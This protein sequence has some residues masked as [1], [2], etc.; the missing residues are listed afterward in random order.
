MRCVFQ[1]LFALLIGS[2]IAAQTPGV[3]QWR[4]HL[5]YS[6]IIAV[7]ES[8]DRVYA[9]ASG[10]VFALVKADN[11]LERLSK[12]N[13]LSDIDISTISYNPYNGKLIIAYT[14]GNLDVVLKKAITN[15]PDIKL[16]TLIGNKTI[17]GIFFSNQYAY[18]AT[19]FGIV[20]FDT[21]KMEVSATYIIGPNSTYVNVLGVTSDGQNLYAATT[22]TVYQA[23]LSSPNLSDFNN[24]TVLPGKGG[25][26]LPNGV[27][28]QIAYIKGS[29]LL[30][31]SYLQTNGA[32]SINKDTIYQFT[33]ALNKWQIFD[34]GM[35][36]YSLKVDNGFI[37][38]ATNQ[39]LAVY[40]TTF[41]KINAIAQYPFGYMNPNMAIKT[42]AGPIEV[43][44]GD[45]YYGLVHA[46]NNYSGQNYFPNGPKRS[47][48]YALTSNS[49]VIAMAPGAHAD[50][51]GNMYNNAGIS[52]FVNETWK[53]LNYM[54]YAILGTDYDFLSAA[55]DPRNSSHIMFGSLGFGVFEFNNN[56]MGRVWSY[57][58]GNST[59]RPISPTDTL[60][61][62][63][64][65]CYDPNGNLWMTNLFTPYMIQCFDAAGTWHA[66]DCTSIL[67]AGNIEIGPILV[68]QNGLKWA[69]LPRGRGMMIYDDKGTISNPNDDRLR[70]LT[71]SPGTGGLPGTEVYC[72]VEDA[73]Q[74][75]WVGTDAGIAVFYNP[76]NMFA[77]SGYDAQQILIQQG[78][79]VQIL[80]GT[81]T[82]TALA[83]DGANRKW[84]GTASGGIY[85]MSADGTQQILN[86]NKDN[87]PLLSNAINAI[88][89]NGKNGEVFIG[90]DK[91]VV[92]YRSTATDGDSGF[93]DVYAY[94]NPVK[95]DYEGP[96]AIA[97]LTTNADVKITDI[98]GNLIFQ[99]KALG[100]QAIWD[101]KNFKG[102]RAHTG[103]YIVFCSDSDGKQTFVTKIL[104]IN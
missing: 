8:P 48:C 47:D 53:T 91:G 36:C 88:T 83:I 38:T 45:S 65:M 31:Y 51:W 37:V 35:S 22:N 76:D 99:T 16:S 52:T 73:N 23:S 49:G 69:I 26:A 82:V 1:T 29:V 84:I 46:H 74:Q 2:V 34:Q 17:N 103:V 32:G 96:I 102:E 70:H 79:H 63:G 30:C 43:W 14:D 19:G 28:N 21:D 57:N 95:H 97:G 68:G 58:R 25:H 50:N 41:S 20:V 18:L 60:T 67:Q 11:S 61:A 42:A 104:F 54:D 3:G 4:D 15:V 33:P 56:I 86:F 24:W 55:I 12:V 39:Y 6:N 27:Y 89:I 94:P 5:P 59:L 78:I 62:I 44:V 80:M 75:I 98:T 87:S 10:G 85:L 81:Q 13:G 72:L 93:N 66:F 101:G 77:N 71:F 40:D 7:A 9:A 90:T 92:S 64:G 100:G